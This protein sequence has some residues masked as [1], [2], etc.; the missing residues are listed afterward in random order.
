MSSKST[1]LM[2][3]LVMVAILAPHAIV[4]EEE[5][6]QFT[7]K[8]SAELDCSKLGEKVKF[9]AIQ[10]NGTEAEELSANEQVIVS[11]NKVIFKDLRR[12]QILPNYYCESEVTKKR[13]NFNKQIMPFLHRPEKPSQTITQGGYAEFICKILYGEE[14]GIKWEWTKE[15]SPIESSK[16][17]DARLKIEEESHQTKL[18]IKNVGEADK[19]E[20]KCTLTNSFGNATESIILRVKN[21]LAALWPFLAIVGEVVVLC[22]I[23]L[24]YEKKC[25]KKNQNEEDNEQTQPMMRDGQNSELKKRT[26]KA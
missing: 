19:G 6:I 17:E 8:K 5:T 1:M 24:V 18:F 12:E 25:T 2:G 22:V 13:I 15:G 14:Q 10:P 21:P 16:D 9:Y 4:G 3:A 11:D 20:Y 26:A 23:I 7:Y